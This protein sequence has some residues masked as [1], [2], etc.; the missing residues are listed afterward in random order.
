MKNRSIQIN[1]KLIASFLVPGQGWLTVQLKF[2]VLEKLLCLK[3]A[4]IT[5]MNAMQKIHFIVSST[6][7]VFA[8]MNHKF[9]TGSVS[10]KTEE[11]KVSKYA[12]SEN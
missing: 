2:Q 3:H 4:L 10:A 5:K 12:V 6:D 1:L 7:K 11:T 9:A 8:S